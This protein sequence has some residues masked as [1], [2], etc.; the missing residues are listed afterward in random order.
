MVG[1]KPPKWCPGGSKIKPRGVENGSLEASGAALGGPWRAK[2]PPGAAGPSSAPSCA[3][4]FFLAPKMR[5]RR[6]P[7]AIL[8]PLG[9]VLGLPPPPRRAPGGHFGRFFETSGAGP[10][11]IMFSGIFSCFSVSV[12]LLICGWLLASVAFRLARPARTRT[13]KKP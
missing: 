7:G 2:W 12:S 3:L 4:F 10:R 13:S 6:P 1:Q 11:K 5:F 9:V 8:A